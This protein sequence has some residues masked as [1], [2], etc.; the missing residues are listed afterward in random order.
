MEMPNLTL[1]CAAPAGSPI[2]RVVFALLLAVLIQASAV[3]AAVLSTT[4]TVEIAAIQSGRT[5][6]GFDELEVPA[7][8]CFI[9]LDRNQYSALEILISAKVDRSIA[10]HLA[11]LPDCGQ[12][13][14]TQSLPNIIG[15][16]TGPRQ[17]GLARARAL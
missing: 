1:E 5:L 7:G 11:R 10:T 9:P 6:L 14:A 15:G 12:F 16:G 4:N 17:P 3:S 2:T 8:P 13:G